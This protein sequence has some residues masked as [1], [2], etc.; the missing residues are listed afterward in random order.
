MSNS[1]EKQSI[2]ENQKKDLV[3]LVIDDEILFNDWFL[4]NKLIPEKEYEL[5]FLM[6]QLKL[7]TKQVKTVY[8]VENDKGDGPYSENS[9]RILNQTPAN[10]RPTPNMDDG[11]IYAF[12]NYPEE[13]RLQR[14]WFDE[15]KKQATKND[16]ELLF[17]FSS[18][19]QLWRWFHHSE[20]NK[21]LFQELKFKIK[22][23]H[24]VI[25]FDSGIQTIFWIPKK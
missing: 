4:N 8:R 15:F 3:N 10:G 17:G 9:W 24:N 22:P 19:R 13:Y 21:K 25:G 16:M 5:S 20:E 6:K 12:N 18:F 11:F 1:F 2:V 23:Y 7:H 14:G